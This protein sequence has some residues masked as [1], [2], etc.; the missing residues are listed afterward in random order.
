MLLGK[1]LL[2]ISG[3]LMSA[4]LEKAPLGVRSRAARLLAEVGCE[5]NAKVVQL[6][7][8]GNNRIYRVES[9][10]HSY[11]LKEYFRH[12]GDTRDR[13][14][15]E[16][17]F[18]KFAWGNGLRCVP[19]AITCDR[20]E[21]LG[22]FGFIEGD[23]IYPERLSRA[24][25]QQA[26]S[27]ISLLNYCREAQAARELPL[28]SEACFSIRQHFDVVEKRIDILRRII[29]TSPIDHEALIFIRARLVPAFRLVTE[30]ILARLEEERIDINIELLPEER[31]ISPSD[32]GFHN[33]LRRQNGAIAF[34]DFE[35][36]GWDD[37][38]K[39]T[40]DFFNQ[41]A[42]PVPFVYKNEV[43][44]AVAETLQKH[45]SALKR[46]NILLPLY[47]MKWCCIL[48]NH[49]L[50]IESKRREFAQGDTAERKKEQ[51]NKAENLLASLE[52][53]TA[54]ILRS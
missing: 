49:F 4:K 12:P 15:A 25:I 43:F 8:G 20:L 53:F 9:G 51:V 40:G 16:F 27:F 23:R 35:Y 2:S 1:I 17:A 6:A 34:L 41:V 45:E 33:A 7:L 21:G 44:A 19:E 37:P 26:M 22:L 29:P 36:A 5:A 50:P 52:Q 54:N 18:V 39:L 30:E 24:D 13:L 14:C 47:R 38:A 42:V 3:W 46:M 32:F 31:V 28:A 10:S 11:V 48:L